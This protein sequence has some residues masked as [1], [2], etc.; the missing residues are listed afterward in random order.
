MLAQLDE[1]S[2]VHDWLACM[3]LPW[4]DHFAELDRHSYF[5]RLCAQAM[6]HPSLRAV[7]TEE[8]TGSLS[9]QQTRAALNRHL[10]LMAASAAT[11]RSGIMEHVIVHMCAER[12][13]ALAD[14]LPTPRRTWRAAAG[15]LI[16]AL[17][18][19]WT[20]P[21]TASPHHAAPRAWT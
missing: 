1:S 2:G 14:G 3:V 15:G 5:A 13:Q 10:P 20:A 16:D 18:G 17:V 7:I 19:V 11:E 6:T 4:T 8:A 12:E 21:V 9:L